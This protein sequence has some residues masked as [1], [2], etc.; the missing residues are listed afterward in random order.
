M[1]REQACIRVTNVMQ[2]GKVRSSESIQ[3]RESFS[4]GTT[5][6]PASATLAY[7]GTVPWHQMPRRS[8]NVCLQ[9]AASDGTPRSRRSAAGSASRSSTRRSISATLTRDWS[10]ARRRWIGHALRAGKLCRLGQDGHR[11]RADE[12]QKGSR[13]NAC[14]HQ[15]SVPGQRPLTVQPI[16]S[17]AASIRRFSGMCRGSRSSVKTERW[18]VSSRIISGLPESSHPGRGR[19]SFPPLECC[20]LP[21]RPAPLDH[22][23]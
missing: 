14:I 7:P 23:Q 19:A 5:R 21:R 18:S 20:G 8:S 17:V 2:D 12:S 9:T 11:H 6:P 3:R 1:Q 10:S 22:P 16:G 4:I 13:R 15:S